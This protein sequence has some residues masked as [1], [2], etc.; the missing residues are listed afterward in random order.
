MISPVPPRPRGQQALDPEI[1]RANALERRQRAHQHVVLTVVV[2]APLDG[3]DVGGFLDDT[4]HPAV[5][6][7]VGAD[8]A[9]VSVRDVVAGRA[10]DHLVLHVPK[11][12]GEVLGLVARRLHDVKGE[13]LRALA[14]DAGQALQLLDQTVSGSGCDI[15]W[16]GRIRTLENPKLDAPSRVSGLASDL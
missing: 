9:R 7:V 3:Q 10:V 13:S 1:V 5:T 4:D 14:P 2:A 11:R 16:P 15:G 6:C 12:F 8:G